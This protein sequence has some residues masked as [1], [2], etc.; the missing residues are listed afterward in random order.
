MLK[1]NLKMV[2]KFKLSSIIIYILILSCVLYIVFLYTYMTQ[3]Y[4]KFD[5]QQIHRSYAI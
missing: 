1:Y 3:T 5:I 2:F 4:F